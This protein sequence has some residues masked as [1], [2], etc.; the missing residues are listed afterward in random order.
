MIHV[1]VLLQ[2]RRRFLHFPEL[3]VI[4]LRDKNILVGKNLRARCV[5]KI[6]IATRAV[7]VCFMPVRRAGCALSFHFL[8][9]MTKRGFY[10][11]FEFDFVLTFRIREYLA[12]PL[13]RAH[14]IMFVSR[15]RT[16]C[17]FGLDFFYVVLFSAAAR[18]KGKTGRKDTKR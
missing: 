4:V 10:N 8:R 3:I 5:R 12:T 9:I 11:V 16:G 18:R 15:F 2:R 1:A 13:V 14:V 6:Q 7:V 17:G